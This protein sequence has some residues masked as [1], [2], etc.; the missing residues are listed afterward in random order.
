[1]S[2]KEKSYSEFNGFV[3]LNLNPTESTGIYISENKAQINF[4]YFLCDSILF[5]GSRNGIQSDLF[6][7]IRFHLLSTYLN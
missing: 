7:P 5:H 6:I 3:F 2:I 1:M 4:M